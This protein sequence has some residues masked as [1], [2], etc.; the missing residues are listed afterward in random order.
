MK[1]PRDIFA[2]MRHQWLRLR[3]SRPVR[4]LLAMLLIAM[5]LFTLIRLTLLMRNLTLLKLGID[6]DT[7]LVVG[8]VFNGMRFDLAWLAKVWILPLVLLTI[9][10]YI[11]RHAR[12]IAISAVVMLCI[13]VALSLI[14]AIGNIPYFEHFNNHVNAMA[15]KY[16]LNDMGD[17][18]GMIAGDISYLCFAIVSIVVAAGFCFVAVRLARHYDIYTPAERR[19][20]TLIAMLII[21]AIIPLADRGFILKKHVL[22]P[23]D[24]MICNN[25]FINKLAVNPVEPFLRSLIHLG[26]TS[27]HLID[28]RHAAAYVRAELGR[29]EN[30]T[31]HIEGHSSP[32]RNV[33]IILMES[34]SSEHMA[35][36]GNTQGY[37]PNLDRLANEGLYYANAYSTG[38]HTCNAIYSVVTSMP[39]YVD[40]HPMQDGSCL[41]LDSIYEQLHERDE[42]HTLFFITHQPN[43]DNVRDFVTTQGFERLISLD[44]YD[45]TTDHVWGVRDH[46][47]FERTIYE[48]NKLADRDECFAAICLTCTNHVPYLVPDVE[49]FTPRSSTLEMQALEYADWSLGHFMALASECSWYDET[50]FVITGD[51]GSAIGV[52]YE[53]NES[54]NH[55][56][57]IFYSP[58][59][60][61]P[62]VRND[63]V[64][65]M[66]IT[67]TAMSMLGVEY[68]NHTMG[69]DLT[70]HSRRMIPYGADGHIAARDEHWI[71][72]YDVYND[73]DFL[74]DLDAEG[75][76][77]YINMASTYPDVVS[78]MYEYVASMV[79]AGWDMHNNPELIKREPR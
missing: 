21:G 65:Q 25:T 75:D 61:A 45:T 34:T 68:D 55:V 72:N 18:M 58:K 22:Q 64:S 52:D 59:H 79:Q 63:L 40:L 23:A 26:D 6:N 24:G 73:I 62:E 29:G 41:S 2:S 38:T 9:A 43:F 42:L 3:P 10:Q 16:M 31:E 50:L 70:Q 51:H 15:M 46:E 53:I 66:D 4:Y 36:E 57:L 71:Y 32:W 47:M 14:I 37:T 19:T 44:D 27:L 8:Q 11:P 49:G 60:I 5:G 54:F 33:V 13:P 69:I 7:W 78:A 20:R 35:I 30:F 39:S 56:P 77:R 76:A 28:S 17:A 12:H 48:L 1:Q 67:P 74:Y